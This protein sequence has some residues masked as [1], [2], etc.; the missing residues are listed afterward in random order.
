MST[1]MPPLHPVVRYNAV[2][3]CEQ[4]FSGRTW[5]V[6]TLASPVSTSAVDCGDGDRLSMMSSKLLSWGSFFAWL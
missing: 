2:V 5:M 6:A 1:D 3:S 4:W